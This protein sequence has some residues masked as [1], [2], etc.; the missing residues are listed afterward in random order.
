M[1]FFNAAQFNSRPGIVLALWAILELPNGDRHFCG[2]N[3]ATRKGR[4]S[5]AIRTFDVS[6]LSGITTSG[7]LYRLSGPPC[8][9]G[10]AER[11]SRILGLPSVGEPWADVTMEIWEFH[12]KTQAP[13]SSNDPTQPLAKSLH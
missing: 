4:A 9:G 2:F 5:T 6:L 12:C 8:N 1:S 11:V 3:T 10:N 13:P 7:R